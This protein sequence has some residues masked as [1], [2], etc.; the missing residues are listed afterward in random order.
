LN[1]KGSLIATSTLVGF[2]PGARQSRARFAV[3][4]QSARMRALATPSWCQPVRRSLVGLPTPRI[5]P[6]A[7]APSCIYS[8]RP[9]ADGTVSFV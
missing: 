1:R 6:G 3:F 8:F 5:L 2:E 7:Q 4:L 9:V